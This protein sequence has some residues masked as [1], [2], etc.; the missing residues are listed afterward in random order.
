MSG[1]VTG[2]NELDKALANLDTKVARKVTRTAVNA[3]LTAMA[4]GIRTA[5]SAAPIS[6]QLKRALKRA[7]GKRFN[8]TRRG[9]KDMSAKAGFG[10]GKKRKTRVAK[11]SGKTK[12]GVGLSAANAHWFLLGTKDRTTKTSGRYTGRIVAVRIIQVAYKRNARAVFAWMERVGY[13]KLQSEIERM[14]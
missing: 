12:G 9:S 4:K 10:V 3:G 2:I 5:I 14:A 11:R 1:Q 13:A 8:R 7:V 6:P